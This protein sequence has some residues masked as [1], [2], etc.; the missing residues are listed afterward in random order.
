M[1]KFFDIIFLHSSLLSLI[2]YRRSKLYRKH[3][4]WTIKSL[5]QCKDWST[6]DSHNVKK[7]GYLCIKINGLPSVIYYSKCTVCKGKSVETIFSFRNKDYFIKKY[8]SCLTHTLH[9]IYDTP[10]TLVSTYSRFRKKKNFLTDKITLS[11][12]HLYLFYILLYIIHTLLFVSLQ[13]QVLFHWG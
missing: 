11:T 6:K 2:D 8:V 4:L 9:Q 3:T 5:D 12:L 13:Y 10:Y 7:R 1:N